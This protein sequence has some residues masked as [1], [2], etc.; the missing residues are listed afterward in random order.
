MPQNICCIA[1][2]LWIRPSLRHCQLAS[3]PQYKICVLLFKKCLEK[4]NFLCLRILK[5]KFDILIPINSLTQCLVSLWDPW[6][7]IPPTLCQARDARLISTSIFDVWTGNTLLG[8]VRL[9]DFWQCTLWHV[10]LTIED[11]SISRNFY[12]LGGGWVLYLTEPTKHLHWLSHS[13][14]FLEAI[15]L[16][17][18]V[19]VILNDNTCQL[20]L[21]VWPWDTWRVRYWLIITSAKC[22]GTSLVSRATPIL[23]V[24][25]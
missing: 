9:V 22:W 17:K 10:I 5:H 1:S 13:F 18:T 14:F 2:F 16:Y 23:V 8:E 7:C 25:P 20:V 11:K 19:E 6:C 24:A 21:R 15:T 3:R 12:F 4:S